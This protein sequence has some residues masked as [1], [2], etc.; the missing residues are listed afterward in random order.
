MVSPVTAFLKYRGKRVV[1]CPE[2]ESPA[3]VEVDA[4]HAALTAVMG[5]P[6]LRLKECSRWPERG[7]CGQECLAQIESAPEDCLVRN[8]LIKWYAGK[9]C[10]ICQRE[11]GEINWTERKPA[12]LTP[13]RRTVEWNEIRAEDLPDTLAN[14]SPICWN[15]HLIETFRRSHPDLVLEDRWRPP[16]QQR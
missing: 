15:C 7:D 1:T 12:L 8:I 6:D 2:T 13:D 9:A 16:V 14:H 4:G 3:G 11:L 10:A 5:R